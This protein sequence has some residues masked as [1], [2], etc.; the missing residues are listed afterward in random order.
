MAEVC[1]IME[2]LV[3]DFL[4]ANMLWQK[5]IEPFGRWTTDLL[6][7]GVVVVKSYEVFIATKVLKAGDQKALDRWNHHGK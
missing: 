5:G 7:S 6:M 1:F 2:K 3:L 4:P